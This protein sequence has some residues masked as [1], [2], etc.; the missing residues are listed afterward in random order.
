MIWMVSHLTPIQLYRSSHSTVPSGSL[1]HPPMSK[2]WSWWIPISQILGPSSWLRPW[3]HR[4]RKGKPPAFEAKMDHSWPFMTIQFLQFQNAS[5]WASMSWDK[6]R[7]LAFCRCIDRYQQI[8]DQ[9]TAMPVL[10]SSV[11][12]PIVKAMKV[13]RKVTHLA[14]RSTLAIE[15]W[16]RWIQNKWRLFRKD[17]KTGNPS[18]PG[19]YLQETTEKKERTVQAFGAFRHATGTKYS[20]PK[21]H[22]CFFLYPNHPSQF[23]VIRYHGDL[24]IRPDQGTS[25]PNAGPWRWRRRSAATMSWKVWTW[26]P[27]RLESEVW[28]DGLRKKMCLSDVYVYVYIKYIYTSI[29]YLYIYIHLKY[30]INVSYTLPSS[31]VDDFE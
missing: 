22:P 30:V 14:L 5:F 24:G 4:E 18:T 3:L 27:M 13:N 23:Q 26:I 10:W 31:A 15:R 2:P 16:R 17:W 9:E 25:S 7:F 1:G 6:Y 28:Q 12:A 11:H 21:I 29:S 20:V 19:L 8:C